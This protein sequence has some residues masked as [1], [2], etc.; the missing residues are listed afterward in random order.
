MK[1]PKNL[2]VGDKFRVIEG[3]E[4]FK[5]GEIISLKFDDGTVGPYFWNADKSLYRY[6]HFSRLEPYIKTIRDVQVGDVVVGYNSEFEY[7]VL[8]RGQSTVVLSYSNDFKKA[9]SGNYTFDQLEEGFTLK[10]EPEVVDDK[11]VLSMN[12]IAEKFGIEVS[13]LK[14]TK[15]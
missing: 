12:E 4:D 6:I 7:L 10:A 2:K 9:N 14:I 8:E 15:E 13:N 11:I 5:L 1:R 3:D